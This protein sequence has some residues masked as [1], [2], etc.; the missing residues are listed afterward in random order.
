[1]P[2]LANSSLNTS[3]LSD[4]AADISA[5]RTALGSFSQ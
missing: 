2:R 5:V 1:M 4:M 3:L